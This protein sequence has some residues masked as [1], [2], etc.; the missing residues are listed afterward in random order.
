[1]SRVGES[2][3]VCKVVLPSVSFASLVTPSPDDLKRLPLVEFSKQCLAQLSLIKLLL[4]TELE[5]SLLKDLCRMTILRHVTRSQYTLLSSLPL[6]K[7]L[8]V[9]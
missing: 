6:P 3:W 5:P 4:S 1:M 9:Q 7:H 2:E 8:Q